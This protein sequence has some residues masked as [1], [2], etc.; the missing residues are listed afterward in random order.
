MSQYDH[1]VTTQAPV[2][3]PEPPE[4]HED[5]GHSTAAWTGVTLMIIGAVVITV[6]IVLSNDPMT[7]GG[8]ALAVIGALA[9][10]VMAKMG[11]GSTHDE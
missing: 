5:H 11:Y 8:T 9:W 3:A 2:R 10:P 6:G 1:T 4:V 7:W